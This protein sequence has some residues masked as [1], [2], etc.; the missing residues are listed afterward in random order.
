MPMP[1]DKLKDAGWRIVGMNHY[2]LKGECHLFVAM[3]KPG[4]PAIIA[5]GVDEAKVFQDLEE[6]AFP[7][8]QIRKQ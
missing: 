7:K 5:E 4:E 2:N 8:I 6:Q 3:M 1:W